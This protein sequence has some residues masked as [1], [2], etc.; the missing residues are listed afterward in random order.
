[1]IK[2]LLAAVAAL[3]TLSLAAP[4]FAVPA[5]QIAP[6]PS[7]P[8]G[9][10]GQIQYNNAGA[11]G[12]S[13]VTV[14]NSATSIQFACPNIGTNTPPAGGVGCIGVNTT[15]H[16]GTLLN[17]DMGTVDI[18]SGNEAWPLAVVAT[19]SPSIA[20]TGSN[21]SG[22]ATVMN[23]I[24]SS[25]I[26]DLGRGQVYG[27]QFVS[28]ASLGASGK[29][30]NMYSVD[31]PVE[32][33]GSGAVGT[34]YAAFAHVENQGTG[35]L[36]KGVDYLAAG[37]NNGG[38]AIARFEGLHVN[39]LPGTAAYGIWMDDQ[40]GQVAIS[41][42]L[43]AVHFGGPLDVAVA[44]IPDL[45]GLTSI[46]DG[47]T[48]AARLTILGKT[49]QSPD[50]LDIY[51]AGVLKL[52]VNNAGGLSLSDQDTGMGTG[53][54]IFNGSLQS[55][56]IGGSI[57]AIAGGASGGGGKI[58]WSCTTHAYDANCAGIS[59]NAS[60]RLEVNNG[61]LG[62]FADLVVR[63]QIWAGQ[64]QSVASFGT[65]GTVI[66]TR[67]S[68][69]TSAETGTIAA[70]YVSALGAPSLAAGAAV[71]YTDAANLFIAAPVASTNVTITNLWSLILGAGIKVTGNVQASGTVQAK[72]TTTVSG[73][74]A[75]NATTA[76]TWDTVTDATAPTYRGALTGSGAVQVPVWCNGATSAWESH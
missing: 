63:N 15:P 27:G 43:G 40:P 76:G 71:T 8:A 41:T 47:V 42:G 48:N 18:H 16:A 19:F 4:S 33:T 62:T 56:R 67:A 21:N 20:P 65:L 72:H 34:A 10:T 1:M 70:A 23:A 75:C 5:A 24:W 6:P 64:A 30:G 38:G 22:F 53:T 46:G 17:L 66:S 52:S 25:N 51:A 29:L 68:T 26:D 44:T 49:G 57:I 54:A 73:L 14:T 2:R 31:L 45:E 69:I 13:P 7:T 9:T 28:L 35:T 55:M 12:G 3:V 50:L 59:L 37:V 11:F 39:T 74:A 60:G 36:T 61:T 58:T 32:M